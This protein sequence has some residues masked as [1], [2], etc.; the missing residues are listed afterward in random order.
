MENLSASVAEQ[1]R[2]LTIEFRGATV[3]DID[4]VADEKGCRSGGPFGLHRRR[5]WLRVSD[6][7]RRRS[8][9]VLFLVGRFCNMGSLAR[10]AGAEQRLMQLGGATLR[11][12]W[13][14]MI[15]VHLRHRQAL[16]HRLDAHTYLARYRQEC[17]WSNPKM[18]KRRLSATLRQR[19]EEGRSGP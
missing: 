14:L 12:E 2:L 7:F 4:A 10:R 8:C 5:A 6:R 9:Y 17:V 15:R 3:Q 11:R 1:I 18:R 16:C 19:M 13:K